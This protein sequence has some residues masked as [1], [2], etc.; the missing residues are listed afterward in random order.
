MSAPISAR[1]PWAV[2]TSMPVTVSSSST[3]WA[4]GAITSSISTEIRP[5]SSSRKSSLDKT[6]ATIRAWWAAEPGG[7]RVGEGGNLPAQM[8]PGQLGQHGGVGGAG[9]QGAQHRPPGHAQDVAGHARQL[10][11]GVLEDL[12]Q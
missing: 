5:I 11:P 9:H 8:A 12:V 10:H 1:M 6:A 2:R 3:W 7:Q 4:K